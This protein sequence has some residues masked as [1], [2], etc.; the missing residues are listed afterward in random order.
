[1][2]EAEADENKV[3]DVKKEDVA[4]EPQPDTPAEIEEV[5]EDL[6]IGAARKEF[7]RFDPLGMLVTH[8]RAS[9]LTIATPARFFSDFIA[10]ALGS[11]PSRSRREE[12]PKGVLNF[13]F[14]IYAQLH[15]SGGTP[16]STAGVSSRGSHIRGV[17]PL[18]SSTAAARL[19]AG[20]HEG[21]GDRAQ[22]GCCHKS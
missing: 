17:C 16:R 13:L 5:V 15:P 11:W 6:G 4:P 20:T 7:L 1:M 3:G 22:Q 10:L 19:H 18:T 12:S 9:D 21:S 2:E 14:S 8:T